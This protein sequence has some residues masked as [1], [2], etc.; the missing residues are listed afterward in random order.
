[1]RV[2]LTAHVV[3]LEQVC[4]R[5]ACIQLA[6]LGRTEGEP[7]PLE[8]LLLAGRLR[9]RTE[10]GDVLGRAG[11]P[12]ELRPERRRR[13]R[14]ELDRIALA[15]DSDHAPL[16]ALQH[17]HDLRQRLDD[18]QLLVTRHDHGETA[19]EVAGAA[20]VAGRLAAQRRCHLADEGAGAVQEHAAARTG[21][22][23]LR[24]AGRDPRRR[25]GADARDRV[26]PPFRSRLAQLG[27]R[28]NA[29]R[30][31]EVAHPFGRQ[32][33]E[34]SHADELRQSLCLELPQLRQLAGV[35]QLA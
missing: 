5:V 2:Q 14:H 4:R 13:R 22:R 6:K 8:Q 3:E 21:R 28:A 7:E 10:A 18:E 19:G 12:H 15:R 32:A 9:Q 1:V 33:Q 35:H 20:G 11:R 25:L 34:A 29:E 16:V 24:Q 27:K 17:R 23:E 31:P 26:E 30:M